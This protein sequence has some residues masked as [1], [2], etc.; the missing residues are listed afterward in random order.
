M[1]PT[2][3]GV[4]L[5]VH[6]N[7]QKIPRKDLQKERNKEFEL[8]TVTISLAATA[9]RKQLSNCHRQTSFQCSHAKPVTSRNSA[10]RIWEGGKFFHAVRQNIYEIKLTLHCFIFPSL[11]D[12]G[13]SSADIILMI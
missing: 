5:R 13:D 11:E 8:I 4:S 10:P 3:D 1:T 6:R 9:K 2:R 7:S 12:K